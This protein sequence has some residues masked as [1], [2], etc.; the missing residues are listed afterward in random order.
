MI[1][2]TALSAFLLNPFGNAPVDE[3]K[4]L[5]NEKFNSIAFIES[6]LTS[7]NVEL[8]DFMAL[9]HLELMA[10]RKDDYQLQQIASISDIQA[11]K[12]RFRVELKLAM[13][14]T[15]FN[16]LKK[17]P[18]FKQDLK[19]FINQCHD[20]LK[21]SAPAI[22]YQMTLQREVA[23][24]H[25]DDESL[26]ADAKERIK[27]A[28]D[29]LFSHENM[30]SLG[31][32]DFNFDEKSQSFQL[33]IQRDFPD[34]METFRNFM[35]TLNHTDENSQTLREMARV[36]EVD[37]EVLNNFFQHKKLEKEK[38]VATDEIKASI[39]IESIPLKTIKTDSVIDDDVKS[40]EELLEQLEIEDSDETNDEAV[41]AELKNQFASVNAFSE[42][43]SMKSLTDVR[44]WSNSKRGNLQKSEICEAIAVLSRGNSLVTGWNGLRNTQILSL[45]TY[46]HA[47]PQHGA[48]YEI[49]TGEG[50]T[51]IIS[52]L[53]V[54]K[55]LMGEKWIDIITS[56]SV[57]AEE[58]KVSRENFFKIFDIT[59]DVNNA[60]NKSYLR[61]AKECY[62]ADIVYGT[63][64]NFQGKFSRSFI[65]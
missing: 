38:T 56:N 59:V 49:K 25:D 13:D 39:P 51:A 14:A 4:S 53:A 15:F 26:T 43:W 57:L 27:Q 45:L 31:K 1:C 12:E 23:N 41:L 42:V 11:M 50:K 34:E 64:G 33:N 2:V 44:D 9:K 58:G 60:S 48:F 35:D 52:L 24:T 16:D 30:E 6:N 46:F 37:F 55:I 28:R 63:M 21:I 3:I 62:K 40:V 7:N 22:N 65:K 32:F 54:I 8:D 61:D 19:T 18:N 36:L 5:I 29:S 10:I 17:T 47:K 20:L